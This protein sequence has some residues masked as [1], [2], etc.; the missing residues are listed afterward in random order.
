MKKIIIASIMAISAATAFAG[1]ATAEYQAADG[2]YGSA[3]NTALV[4]TVKEN[5]TSNIAVDIGGTNTQTAGTSALSTRVEGGVT[6]S[7]P[8][9][10]V[11]ASARVGAGEQ[12]TNG[13]NTEYWSVEPAVAYTI[14][15]KWSTKLGYRYRTAVDGG[16]AD[17]TRTWRLGAAY[18]VTKADSLSVR[19][20]QVRGDSNT[21]AVA[22]SFT[23]SF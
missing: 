7:L 9:G 20:D 17:Q 22:V 21:N 4:L 15:N 8:V 6:Y 5:I 12:Y 14:N 13:T 11:V 3:G 10:P 16:V 2:Q 1:S 18:A 23:H 19:L